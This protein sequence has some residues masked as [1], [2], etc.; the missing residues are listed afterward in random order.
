MIFDRLLLII[1][2]VASAFTAR[3]EQ[4][5]LPNTDQTSEPSIINTTIGAASSVSATTGITAASAPVIAS[6][7]NNFPITE[8]REHKVESQSPAPVREASI[9][10]VL[11]EPE[12]TEQQKDIWQR[13]RTGFAMNSSSKPLIARHERWYASQPEYV[14][15]MT[16]RA[17]RYLY[18]I[19]EEVERRGMPTEIALLPMIE[20]AFNPEA[21]SPSRASG[22]W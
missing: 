17:R 12:A 14:L 8:A 11:P 18:F 7:Q 10:L 16:E 3:A 20:S 2:F 1:F 9:M 4:L 13:I 5:S 15:R 22:I 21:Y 6:T 19:T